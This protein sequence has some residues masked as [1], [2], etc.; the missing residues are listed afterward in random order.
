MYT[1]HDILEQFRNLSKDQLQK[2]KLFE[3][4]I[5]QFLLTDPQYAN[6]LDKVWMWNEWP[7]R[8]QED[9]TGIDLVAQEKDTGD[10]W[11]IQCKFYKPGTTLK[12]EHISSFLADSTRVFDVDGQERTFAYR[13]IV[14]TSDNWGR[15]A[16]NVIQDQSVPVGTLYL[17][18]LADSAVDWSAF[19][20]DTPQCMVLRQKKTL[21]DHQNE[22]IDAVLVG[23]ETYDRGKL[24]MACGTGKTFTALRL[25]E[26]EQLVPPT[27]RILFLA[28]SIHLVSQTL[29]EWTAEAS[30]PFHAF[31]VCSDTKV[32]KEEEDIRTHD[33]AYPATTDPEKLARALTRVSADRRTV[34]FST[35][36]S[37]QTVIDAQR[38]GELDA[39]DLVICDEAHRNAAH[40]QR[41]DQDEGR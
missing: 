16:E 14:S 12:K 28:P 17:K 40:L 10:Y 33:L 29:R 5:A 11:A 31:V 2:G 6:R 35:Y 25:A 19:S 4:M 1:V 37:I 27:G 32:G 18:D 20:I 38:I 13:L 9:N 23:F 26:N 41:R 22:A 30:K 7:E 3:K 39:F 21:R 34:V 8:W 15:N 24:I 36:Q